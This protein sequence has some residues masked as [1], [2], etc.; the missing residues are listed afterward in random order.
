LAYDLYYIRHV[1]LWLDVRILAC[2]LFYLL[3]T[4]VHLLPRLG[5]VPQRRLIEETYRIATGQV[6]A[7]AAV[8]PA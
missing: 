3:C 6:V 7:A 4:P 8:R 1:G 2:T 5:L